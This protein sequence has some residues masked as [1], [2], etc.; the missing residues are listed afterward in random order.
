MIRFY[1]SC[2]LIFFAHRMFMYAVVLFGFEE[3]A[4][5]TLAGTFHL[6]AYGPAV[7]LSVVVGVALDRLSR[8]RVL[9]ATIAALVICMSVMAVLS[10]QIDDAS[11]MPLLASLIAVTF[12]YGGFY[13]ALRPSYY[14]VL[15]LLASTQNLGRDT[16]SVSLVS[17][18]AY[19][20]SPVA[21]GL[22]RVPFDW[23]MIFAL[24]ALLS[25]AALGLV[26]LSLRQV[27]TSSMPTDSGD[28]ATFIGDVA[29]IRRYLRD[30]PVIWQLLV[31]FSLICLM[32]F[33]PFQVLI[34]ALAA[35]AM[36]LH[37]TWQGVYMG[38]LGAG[39]VIG[40]IISYRLREVHAM[41]RLLIITTV[42]GVVTSVL[43]PI[44]SPLWSGLA[45]LVAS[46]CLGVVIT[47][48]TVVIQREV[49]EGL[50]GRLLGIYNSLFT[51]L[52]AVGGFAAGIASDFSPI[53]ILIVVVSL[54]CFFGIFL[55]IAGGK[56][57]RRYTTG[58]S[59]RG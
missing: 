22:L 56:Q 44:L 20:L 30:H 21:V 55:C 8:Q 18:L 11:N 16:V 57:L 1:L 25:T 4:S 47:L 31:L 35:D 37:E 10:G 3:F 46:S 49:P 53:P 9:L 52:T 38:L 13:V 15:A 12:V 2:F 28:S 54:S 41:G 24:M 33:G 48:V 27:G 14:A 23:P 51:G 17:S 42:V 58:S 6:G 50:R 45:I 39:V 29:E 43:V 32:I 7:V 34:P 59:T 40:A 26:F 19:P 5:G 36:A